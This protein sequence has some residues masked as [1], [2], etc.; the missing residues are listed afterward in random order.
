MDP[1]AQTGN[2]LSALVRNAPAIRQVL[3]LVGLAVSIGVGLAAALWLSDSGY[4]TLYANISDAEASEIVVTLQSNGIEYELDRRTGAI[5]VPPDLIHEARLV[6]ASD[7][8]PRGAGYGMEMVQ[9]DNGITSSQMMENARLHHALETELARTIMELKPVQSARVH[10]TVPDSS[11]FVRERRQRKASVQVSLFPGRTLESGQV[12]AIVQF[13]A[14]SIPE[15]EAGNVV[16]LDQNSQLLS[17]TGEDDELAMS[18]RQM[19]F[20]RNL[21]NDYESRI[22]ALLS[23]LVGPGNFTATVAADVDFTIQEESREEFN[24]ANTVVRSEQIQED[25]NSMGG[26]T[27]AGVP[28]ALSNTPPQ[29]GAAAAANNAAGGAEQEMMGSESVRQTRNFEVDRTLSVTRRQ[30]GAINSLAVAVTLNESIAASGQ[31]ATE[32]EDAADGEAVTEAQGLPIEE[33]VAK[34]EQ[35]ARQAV[36]FNEARGDTI[37]VT[38]AP[39]FEAP[40]MPEVEAPSYFTSPEFFGLL[41]QG[42]SIAAILLVGFGLVRPIVRMITAPAPEPAVAGGAAA[43]AGAAATVMPSQLSYDE[44]VGAVRQLVDRDSERVARIVKE[45]VGAD[46]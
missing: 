10:I 23:P 31:V 39:F 14:G 7:G 30:P 37:V 5:M 41:R 17:G 11:V 4:T 46:G 32:G 26:T 35:L 36:G 38:P 20:K 12:Q 34:A 27:P 40:P 45:W 33:L 16:V 9:A 6:L 42:L 28:G 15:L 25:R 2:N 13:V 24:P 21:E 44:K 29:V 43:L 22:E 1:E 8:L 19:Q 3:L 18:D